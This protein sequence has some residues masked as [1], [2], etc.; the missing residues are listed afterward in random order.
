MEELG[1]FPRWAWVGRGEVPGGG[2]S[3]NPTAHAPDVQP[4]RGPCMLPG[5]LAWACIHTYMQAWA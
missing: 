5:G 4:Y 2:N 3:L 1:A